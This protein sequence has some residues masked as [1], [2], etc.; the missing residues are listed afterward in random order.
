MKINKKIISGIIALILFFTGSF[1]IDQQ[2]ETPSTVAENQT[3]IELV[4]TIDGD[5]IVFAEDGEEKKLRLLLI[6]TPENST[7]KT[8]SAQPYGKEAK[9]FLTNYLEGKNYR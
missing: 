1:V 3:A 5:T 6:D 8:G 4:R 9:D 2:Q 7:T